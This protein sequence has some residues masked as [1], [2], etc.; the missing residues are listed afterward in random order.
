METNEVLSR[1]IKNLREKFAYTQS[2]IADYLG[3]TAAAVNQYENDARSIPENVVEKLALL[4]N[5]QEY[6]LYEENP[7]KQNLLT[8]FAFRADE[9]KPEDMETISRF[10][11][12]I[13]NYVNMSSALANG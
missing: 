1:N 5:V 13:T 10:K 12:I 8:S 2:F 7:E 9:I 11:K 3:I 4:Y 6:D